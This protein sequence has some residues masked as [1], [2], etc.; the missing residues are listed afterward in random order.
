MACGCGGV[1]AW[2]GGGRGSPATGR[3]AATKPNSS[4][5][6][7]AATDV[8]PSVLPIA[9]ICTCSVW[10]PLSDAIV[11]SPSTTAI[12]MNAAD[13]IPGPDVG[14]HA[15]AGSS[16][17]SLRPATARPRRVSAGRST[18]ARIDRAVRER[19]HQHDVDEGQR[20]RGLTEE[21]RHPQVDVAQPDDDH[22]RGDRQAAAGTGTRPGPWP[23]AC[24]AAPRSSSAPGSAAS[25]PR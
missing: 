1:E 12:E 8:G 19:Q 5:A 7:D 25:R 15:P 14:H 20:Q 17:S 24:A 4:T 9:T 22:Q 13:R 6:S 23:T 3:A 2:P 16:S 21:V 10:Y 11:Y 18:T